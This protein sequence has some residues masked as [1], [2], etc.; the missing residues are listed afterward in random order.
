MG[1]AAN[2]HRM[3]GRRVEVLRD[4]DDAGRV[5]KGEKDWRGR[6]SRMRR[7]RAYLGDRIARPERR[8]LGGAG[9]GHT[10]TRRH[11]H[12]HTQHP[13]SPAVEGEQGRASQ[14]HGRMALRG[15]ARLGGSG[16]A[17]G[18]CS[19]A[20]LSARLSHRGRQKRGT[21]G[22]G[23]NSGAAKATKGGRARLQFPKKLPPHLLCS[24]L[25]GPS[26]FAAH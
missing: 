2:A 22:A 8:G 23:A 7:W 10:P 16:L 19:G 12:T 3:A 14:A 1:R 20:A 5:P 6:D 26:V 21:R 17:S 9:R 25:A 13:H 11:T 15:S 24:R 4:D 18:L